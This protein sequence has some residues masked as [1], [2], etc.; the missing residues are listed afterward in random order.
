M[1][2]INCRAI[3][4]LTLFSGVFLPSICRSNTLK[5]IAYRSKNSFHTAGVTGSIPVA[6][7]KT[8][9]A[10]PLCL[11]GEAFGFVIAAGAGIAQIA[12][13]K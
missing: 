2:P 6:P 12:R 13:P 4:A 1:M 10:L 8:P 9:F 5:Y 3:T 7:T 11:C